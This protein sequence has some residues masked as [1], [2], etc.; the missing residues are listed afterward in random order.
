MSSELN[1]EQTA[2]LTAVKRGQNI[3]LTGAG[4]TG[5][6]HTIRA[7]VSWAAHA[8]I[9]VAVTAMTGCAALLLNS[10]GSR[11][12]AKT[13]HSWAG[14]GLAREAPH[15]LADSIKKNRK[16]ARRWIDTQ[17]L[18]VDEVSMMTPEFLEKLDL[19]ARR[20]RKSPEVKFGGLQLVL[21]GDFCQLPPISHGDSV[22]VFKS[23]I[24]TALIDETHNLTQIV[25]QS[26]PVFQ[27]LLT[28]ARMGTLSSESLAVLSSR[29]D[30]DWSDNEIKPTLLFIRNAEVNKINKQNMDALEGERR[31]YE[32]KTVEKGISKDKDEIIK[33]C[34]PEIQAALTRLDTDAPY[35]TT[36]EL[37]VGAQVM[38]LT[39]MDQDHGLV[40]GSR[41]VVTGYSPGGLP[42]VRFIG[43][44]DPVIVDRAKWWLAEPDYIGRSQIPLKVAYALTIHKS[45]GATLDSALID[46]GSSTFEYGQAYVALS[47]VRSLESL[48]I[49]ALNPKYIICHPEVRDF[50]RGLEAEKPETL[51]K[52]EEPEKP[53]KPGPETKYG[54]IKLS[55]PWQAIVEPRIHR[56]ATAIDS[57][58][59]SEDQIAPPPADVFA[60]LLSCPD[61]AAIRVVILGQDP[62]PTAGNAHGLA[63]SVRPGVKPAPSLQNIFKEL[64]SDIGSPAPTSGNLQA[65][66]DQGVL[67]LNDLLTV[68]VGKPLSHAGLGWEEL[69]TSVLA[70]VLST[71]P[72]VVVIAWGRPAQKKLKHKLIAP[73]LDKHTIIE[74][75]HPSPLSA[76]TGFFGSK[77][78]SKANEALTTKG[79]TPIIWI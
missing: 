30:L 18:I 14:V 68:T 44:T 34:D 59:L 10:V 22:Y 38:L 27:R 65:W 6:S 77:P 61:P 58:G 60:A 55:A 41:G 40:N 70:A 20:V 21:A 62:Y 16:A 25:R 3:F 56:I 5:K 37:C 8:G 24:W 71:A 23:P 72:H 73:L 46:I 7:I 26:D 11:T 45:Q 52:P 13:L 9:R 39:N 12:K 28:E 53:E 54:V 32:V 64:A 79:Q 19:V 75:P 43:F 76:H 50:Y 4:G 69:T 35:D 66:A 29:K 78:F 51:E 31:V 2:A 1:E 42:L 57:L 74:A 48:Y 67:L 15:E 36:L 47:R 33:T 63:F 49:W 17:L